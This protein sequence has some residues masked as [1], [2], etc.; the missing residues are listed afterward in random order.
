MTCLETKTIGGKGCL[1][2]RESE[3]LFMEVS[4]E[5][6][7]VMDECDRIFENKRAEVEF[8]KGECDDGRAYIGRCVCCAGDVFADDCDYLY[9]EEDDVC[10]CISCYDK[11]LFKADRV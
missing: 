6:L 11:F 2:R 5:H 8:E 10:I 9:N 4:K 1:P 3:V 7:D